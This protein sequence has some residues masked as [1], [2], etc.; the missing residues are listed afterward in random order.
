MYVVAIK[1]TRAWLGDSPMELCM[2]GFWNLIVVWLKVS[3]FGLFWICTKLESVL[4]AHTV[5]LFPSMGPAR[6]DG[7]SREYDSLHGE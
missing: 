7:S 2:I 4:V 6:W 3:K 5:A 1:D